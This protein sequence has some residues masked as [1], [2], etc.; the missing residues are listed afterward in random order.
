MTLIHNTTGVTV[1]GIPP[2]TWTLNRP[3]HVYADWNDTYYPIVNNLGFWNGW[4]CPQFD[5]RTAA[6]IVDDQANLVRKFGNDVDRLEWD[7]DT[8]LHWTPTYQNRTE[9]TVIRPDENGHYIIGAWNWTWTLIRPADCDVCNGP[10]GIGYQSPNN[11]KRNNLRF[12]QNCTELTTRT[13]TGWST[14]STSS[15]NRGDTPS[16]VRSTGTGKNPP[17]GE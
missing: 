7:G 10:I 17:T 12:C 1:L 8:I 5:R 15:S 4:A 9:A 11:D 16:T 13:G 2:G 3:D 14:C 6:K